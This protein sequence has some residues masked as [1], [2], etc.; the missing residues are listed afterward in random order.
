MS[1]RK[2]PRVKSEGDNRK[3]RRSISAQGGHSD[4]GGSPLATRRETIEEEPALPSKLDKLKY[5]P[6]SKQESPPP[7]GMSYL[8]KRRA[9]RA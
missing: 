3:S 1:H 9:E 8:E 5:D 6:Q 2:A 4:S 7:D